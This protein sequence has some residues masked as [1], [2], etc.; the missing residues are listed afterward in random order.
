ML[1]DIAGFWRI[2]AFAIL[3]FAQNSVR[4]AMVISLVTIVI[5]SLLYWH[6]GARYRSVIDKQRQASVA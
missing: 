3:A 2:P 1:S 6:G 4:Y 5:G